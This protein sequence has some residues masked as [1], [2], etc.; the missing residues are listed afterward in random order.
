MSTSESLVLYVLFAFFSLGEVGSL[1][2]RKMSVWAKGN[3]V[4]T[5]FQGA[6]FGSRLFSEKEV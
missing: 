3:H 1:Q 4:A 5:V 2:L 6:A